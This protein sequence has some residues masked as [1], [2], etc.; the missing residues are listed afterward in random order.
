MRV[1]VSYADRGGCAFY[2]LVAPAKV[3]SDAGYDITLDFQASL[4]HAEHHDG[5]VTHLNDL[6]YDVVVFQRPMTSTA[7]Q[8]ISL[9][10]ARGIKVVVELDD[11]YWSISRDNIYWK[12]SQPATSRGANWQFLTDSCQKA[13]LV[14]VSTPALAKKIP[15]PNVRV[16]RNLIPE[17]Y[18]NLKRAKEHGDEL[19]EGKI[20]VGWTGT[21]E[22]HAGD[23]SVVGDSV[24]KA[25]RQHD[26][27]FLCIGSEDS[28]PMM[29]F[30][31]RE[32]LYAPW[33]EFQHY[34]QAV[35]T[36]DLG[37]VPLKLNDFNQA[38]SYLKGLEYAA[39]GIPFVASPTEE[40]QYLERHG[41]GFLAH[42]KHDWY[43][44]LTT[45]LES[46][47]LR[48][49]M[50]WEGKSFAME[51]TYELHAWKWMDAW[52]A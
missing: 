52:S 25:V 16:L 34:P 47:G 8:V 1:L 44:V 22:T 27:R 39:L 23:L 2:R 50:L 12:Y 37:L 19:V 26:A 21:P 35:T 46:P 41:A 28:G 43:R 48:Q 40:Y 36:F 4:I 49:E 3:L 30:L 42:Q 51:S 18:L 31:D 7:C 17:A 15:N 20:V 45:L 5:V 38:K 10:Q 24:A 9:L 13:D 32:A 11:D 33:V 14:T 29:G 6:D